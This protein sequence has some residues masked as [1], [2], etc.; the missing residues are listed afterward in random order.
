MSARD[1]ILTCWRLAVF[2]AAFLVFS[3]AA[4]DSPTYAVGTLLQGIWWGE[5]Q[6]ALLAHYGARAINLRRPVD[7][8]D[9]FVQIVV[10]NVDVGGV[11]LIAFLQIDKRTGGLKRIQLER[12][13][14]GVNPPAFRAVIGALE[15]EYGAPDAM[16]SIPPGRQDGFQAATELVWSRSGNLIR[17]VFRDTTIESFEGCLWGDLKMGPCGLTGQL[18]VRISPRGADASSCPPPRR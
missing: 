6:S 3:G 13:R 5:P 17:A 16:C 2:A 7:F 8:G 11:P 1:P 15:A 18:F 14:H 10:R 4:A 9:S 12:Q